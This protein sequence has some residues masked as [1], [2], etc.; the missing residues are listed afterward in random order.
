MKTERLYK[1]IADCVSNLPKGTIESILAEIRGFE[2]AP[3]AWE[4]TKILIRVPVLAARDLVSSFLNAW[5]EDA[6]D[7]D[8]ITAE[9]MIR[10]AVAVHE[11]KPADPELIWTGPEK[12]AG[13]FRR[14]DQALLDVINHAEKDLFVISFA[15]FYEQT[16]WDAFK[17]AIQR[18]VQIYFIL[19]DNDDK[20]GFT[21]DISKAFSSPVFKKA[22]FYHW[23]KENRPKDDNGKS[24]ASMHAKAVVADRRYLYISSANLTGS[25]MDQNIELGVVLDNPK[26]ATDVCKLFEDMIIDH[27]MEIYPL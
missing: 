15:A 5:C 9:K 1:S 13:K 11:M 10:S 14:T 24:T 16:L 4:K 12:H 2:K 19:E 8:G 26:I 22:N 20:S 23:P 21:G 6:S 25:A 18:N 17:A 3:L 27:T 7:M